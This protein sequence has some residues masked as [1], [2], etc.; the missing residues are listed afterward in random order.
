MLHRMRR[1][2]LLRFVLISLL[3]GYSTGCA[4]FGEGEIIH[5]NPIL[6]VKQKGTNQFSGFL[7]EANQCFKKNNFEALREKCEDQLAKCQDNELKKIYLK[8]IIADLDTRKNPRI[9][10]AFKT[11]KDTHQLLRNRLKTHGPE[12]LKFEDQVIEDGK[13]TFG[14]RFLVG[15]GGIVCLPVLPMA[16]F[17][18]GGKE[19]MYLMPT[20]F[21][22][23]ITGELNMHENSGVAGAGPGN[24][25]GPKK[26]KLK[27][28]FVSNYFRVNTVKLDKRAINN[29]IYLNEMIGDFNKAD[30]W[31][32]LLAKYGYK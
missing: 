15:L 5:S 7:V 22:A 25:T 27:S 24:E 21:A 28:D 16:I 30:Q 11:N 12:A 29:L 4:H 6:Y 14:G 9:E 31:K 26:K 32:S 20:F 19:F 18:E 13:L 17:M 8:M 3:M 2:R 1:F 10:S 23:P